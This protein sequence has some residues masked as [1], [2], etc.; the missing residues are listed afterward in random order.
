MRDVSL[1]I[2]GGELFGVLGP[3][4]AGKTTLVRILSTLLT[5]TAGKVLID[6]RD[7]VSN[8]AVVR[9][10]IGVAFGGERGLYDRL[11]AA[12]NLRFACELYK[13]DR[14]GQAR[15][16]AELLDLVGLADKEKSRVETFSR[17]M[18]QRLHIA[19]ALVHRP[20][21]LFLDEPSTG[22]DP[23]AARSLRDLVATLRRDGTTVVLTTHQMFEA[24]ELCDRVAI[25]S[26][27]RVVRIG[28]PDEIKRS[29]QVG[30]IVEIE[31]AGDL[32]GVIDHIR[33][34]DG[35]AFV[36]VDEQGQFSR[37]VIRL[38]KH[39]TLRVADFLPMLEG[40]R[41]GTLVDRG[42]TLEDAYISIVESAQ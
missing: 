20:S 1:S 6:G 18:K 2:A 12:D 34:I 27:G 37:I 42:P 17:G 13:V 10:S 25:V 8:A 41:V 30:N 21:V 33:G 3:N 11:T 15:R 35:V 5:P 32:S 16:V 19:R 26:G 14:R 39:S 22:L 29:V 9:Q 36:G 24:D 38:E 40:D 23:I 31:V 4:G 28:S 7:V